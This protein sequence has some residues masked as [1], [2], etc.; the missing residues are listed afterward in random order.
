[1]R[2]VLL[3]LVFHP[4]LEWLNIIIPIIFTQLET[5]L[6]KQRPNYTNRNGSMAYF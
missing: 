1:M 3:T 2:L 4:N 6:A 5:L